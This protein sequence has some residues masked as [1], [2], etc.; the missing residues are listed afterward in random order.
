MAGEQGAAA[1]PCADVTE[2]DL[3]Q[4]LQARDAAAFD[5]LFRQHVAK[6]YRQAFHLVGTAAEA[7]EVVQEVFVTVYEKVHTF[8]GASALTT[9]LYRL[10][11]NWLRVLDTAELAQIDQRV[12]QQLHPIVSLLD[13]FKTEQQALQLIFPRKG[14]LDTHPQCMDRFVEEAFASAL[15]R[16]AVARILFDVGDEAHIEN[17][18]PIACGIKAAIEVEIGPSEIQPDLFGHLFQCLQALW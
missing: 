10:T 7:E 2:Q 18:L 5:T 4:R 11:I 9:W 1:L 16:L 6:V 13:A 15:G 14:A 12:C 3:V 8:R 17:A